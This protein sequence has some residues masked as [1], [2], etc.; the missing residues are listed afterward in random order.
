[1]SCC[2]F[3]QSSVNIIIDVETLSSVTKIFR[4]YHYFGTNYR[5]FGDS[6]KVP[7][8]RLDFIEKNFKGDLDR[9]L[10]ECLMT[11]LRNPKTGEKTWEKL[12]DALR[13]I[14]EDDLAEKICCESMQIWQVIT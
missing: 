8:D 7:K 6:L 12:A 14:D 13:D 3:F 10:I 9:C 4:K 1:M 2:N 5:A 11:W